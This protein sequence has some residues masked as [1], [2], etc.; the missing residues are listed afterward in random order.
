MLK[1]YGAHQAIK[2]SSLITIQKYY[3]NIFSIFTH[4]NKIDHWWTLTASSIETYIYAQKW[5]DSTKAT[6]IFEM[7]S[8]FNFCILQGIPMDNPKK[9]LYRR[10]IRKEARFL[11]KEEIESILSYVESHPQHKILILL[12]LTTGLRLSELCSLTK[13]QITNAVLVGNVY[14]INVLGKGRKLRSVFLPFETWNLCKQYRNTTSNLLGL[15]KYAVQYVI[16]AIRKGTNVKFTAHTLRHT[17]LSH[18]A[19]KGADIYRIQKIAGHS[20][21]LTTSLYLH[22]S[23]KELAET[24]GLVNGITS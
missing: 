9:I 18:L 10:P 23:N 21:I 19:R 4:C 24:A 17:Y 7:R 12:F 8:F 22:C 6:S 5:K 11:H 2:G 16:S 13:E 14:Q 3:G 20:S 1:K 15:N